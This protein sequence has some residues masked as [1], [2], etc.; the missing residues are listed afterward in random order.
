MDKFTFFS[1]LWIYEQCIEFKVYNG[2]S[3]L[4]SK[5]KWEYGLNQ[6]KLTTLS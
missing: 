1:D 4:K 2:V 6:N 3:N 5:R